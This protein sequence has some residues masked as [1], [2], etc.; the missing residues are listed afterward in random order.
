[1]WQNH[2][3]FTKLRQT[4]N[5]VH[6]QTARNDLVN[7]PLGSS[8]S[9]RARPRSESWVR[10]HGK[11]CPGLDSRAP[12]ASAWAKGERAA[13]AANRRGTRQWSGFQGRVNP[14]YFCENI[15]ELEN[16]TFSCLSDPA[17]ITGHACKNKQTNKQGTRFAFLREGDLDSYEFQYLPPKIHI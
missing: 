8:I 12:R 4:A 3:L 5:S 16:N 11:R 15:P 7:F 13:M 6:H 9:P 2:V 10:C 14:R 17:P 1:M